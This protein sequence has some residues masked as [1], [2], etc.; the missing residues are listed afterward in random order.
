MKTFT[1]WRQR[2]LLKLKELEIRYRPVRIWV[3]KHTMLAQFFSLWVEYYDTKYI[4]SRDRLEYH[5]KIRNFTRSVKPIFTE[6]AYYTS[7][8]DMDSNRKWVIHG[9][10]RLKRT[11]WRLLQYWFTK[12]KSF[13][14]KEAASTATMPPILVTPA[15]SFHH[16]SRYDELQNK[17]RQLLV[18]MRNSRLCA[19]V[20]SFLKDPRSVSKRRRRL[21][22]APHC[23]DA[24]MPLVSFKQQL[25]HLLAPLYTEVGEQTIMILSFTYDTGSYIIVS[26]TNIIWTAQGSFIST[27]S[28]LNTALADL[29]LK[30]TT[31]VAILGFTI[32]GNSILIL[33]TVSIT[34]H[35]LILLTSE[36]LEPSLLYVLKWTKG[37]NTT[38]RS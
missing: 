4:V 38:R 8:E 20:Q 19:A 37:G 10:E 24:N 14:L 35:D 2:Y 25:W 9:Y 12:T 15:M 22:R 5:F 27:F 1:K 29:M 16:S 26:G 33:I 30:G 21:K 3:D 6:W 31:L 34:I 23:D 32:L 36:R 28:F 11:R 7:M 13:K 17:L 18:Q